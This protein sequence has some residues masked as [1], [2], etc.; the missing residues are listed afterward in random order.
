[1][2]NLAKKVAD[3]RL[4]EARQMERGV[5]RLLREHRPGANFAAVEVMPVKQAVERRITD[6]ELDCFRVE[7]GAQQ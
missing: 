4:S 1:M 3:T 5:F 2:F 7:L 6:C